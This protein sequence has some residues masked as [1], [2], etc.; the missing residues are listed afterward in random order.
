MP[1]GSLHDVEYLVDENQLG[2]LCERDRSWSLQTLSEGVSMRVVASGVLDEAE[3]QTRIHMD[4]R[5]FHENV[6]LGAPA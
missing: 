1:V 2:S 4:G 5:V 6:R 3:D